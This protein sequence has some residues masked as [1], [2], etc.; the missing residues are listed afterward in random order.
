MQLSVLKK[1]GK[2]GKKKVSES[3]FATP[4]NENLVHQSL[5]LDIHNDHTGT[6][7]QKTR[8][9]VRGGGKKPWRQKGTGR[10]RAGTIRSP[11]WRGGGVPFA[12]KPVK[13]K[14]KI[15]KKM[16]TLAIRS[17]L[18]E[19]ARQDRI[20]LTEQIKLEK[21]KTSEVVEIIKK[22]K[23]AEN[24]KL[25]IVVNEIDNNLWLSAR[26]IHK[27]SVA[28]PKSVTTLQLAQHE[29]VLL[30]EAATEKLEKVL[31]EK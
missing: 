4:Y 17:A 26:N 9:Q 29:M 22:I 3:L 5:L 6:K 19:L 31:C 10:A 21:P 8:S 14:V 27:V 7:A 28:E 25:L 11:I 16:R 2:T 15:N 23:D 13:R 20:M 24:K 18:S 12:A 30:E 1:D